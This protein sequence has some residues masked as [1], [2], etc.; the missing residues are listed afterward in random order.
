MTNQ[1][2]VL[3]P[4]EREVLRLVSAG[5]PNSLIRAQLRLSRSLMAQVLDRLY[6]E[7]GLHPAQERSV[8]SELRERLSDWGRGYFN[9]TRR[10]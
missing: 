4:L 3:S 6:R 8:P 1:Q 2:P 7:S 9:Q 10:L 5:L